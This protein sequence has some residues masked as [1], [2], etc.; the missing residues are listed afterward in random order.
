MGM[1]G[2][3]ERRSDNMYSPQTSNM[4][5]RAVGLHSNAAA[6]APTNG[7]ALNNG[8]STGGS[9][10]GRRA[11]LLSMLGKGPKT[12]APMTTSAL[13]A[14][15]AQ[16][17]QPPSPKVT[18]PPSGLAERLAQA[19]LA[20]PKP[21]EVREHAP[22]RRERAPEM[23]TE[24][25]A[26]RADAESLR[27]VIASQASEIRTLTGQ[28]SEVATLRNE[29]AEL[30][31]QMRGVQLDAET[32]RRQAP[33]TVSA[34]TTLQGQLNG[35]QEVVANMDNDALLEML[36]AE[37]SNACSMCRATVRQNTVEYALEQGPSARGGPDDDAL[38]AQAMEGTAS[39]AI[40]AGQEMVLTYPMY[41][42][43]M[44]DMGAEVFMRRRSMD[45]E[46]AQVSYTYV[47]VLGSYGNE[48]VQ[49]VAG[50]AL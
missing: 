50:F 28:L 19:G 7:P 33:D 13:T 37:V 30:W 29:M 25:A 5:A 21:P 3:G 45:P 43:D 36:S 49:Y 31:Q 17:G 18:A 22:E 44:Q 48:T 12:G 6:S 2:A 34:V 16:A 23:Q 9:A 38:L 8:L 27:G 41:T 35:I 26:M 11:D 47:K 14:R 10:G 1:V 4:M 40:P 42:R 20:P 39:S 46:T 24:M 32:E 15:L